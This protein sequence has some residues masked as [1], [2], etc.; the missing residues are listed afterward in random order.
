MIFNLSVKLHLSF[1]NN[2]KKPKKNPNLLLK[3][4]LSR[5]MS[6]SLKT[7]WSH[8]SSNMHKRQIIFA[9]NTIG[10]NLLGHRSW[11]SWLRKLQSK[12][13]KFLR[14]RRRLNKRRKRKDSLGDCCGIIFMIVYGVI[15][16]ILI[17]AMIVGY[18]IVKKWGD[19]KE[20]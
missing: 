16:Y 11:F 20:P 1:V 8:L 15:S 2:W 6:K 4:N 17:L 12:T 13:Y 19:G 5:S 18:F 7:I 3:L 14:N 10:R 9:K